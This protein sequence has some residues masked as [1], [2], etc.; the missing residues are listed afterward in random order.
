MLDHDGLPPSAVMRV[1]DWFGHPSYREDPE[2]LTQSRVLSVGSF[3][4]AVM[5]MVFIFLVEREVMPPRWMVYSAVAAALLVATNPLISRVTGK[6]RI[7]SWLAMLEL[8]VLFTLGS[9]APRNGA[10]FIVPGF[11]LV[12]TFSAFL[13]GRN[14]GIV[15]T[16]I[17]VI[18]IAWI[19]TAANESVPRAIATIVVCIAINLMAIWVID[20]FSRQRAYRRNAEAALAHALEDAERAD[21]ARRLFLANMTHDLKTPMNSILGFA[22]LIENNPKEPASPKQKEFARHIIKSGEQLLGLINQVLDLSEL[23]R[24]DAH[25]ALDDVDAATVI[26]ESIGLVGGQAAAA[27]VTVENLF[28][29]GDAVM[30]RTDAARLG[31]V[32]FN[33]LSNAIQFNRPGGTVTVARGPIEGGRLRIDVIDTGMGIAEEM[34]DHLFEP[35]AHH[36]CERHGTGV[37]IGLAVCKRIID[38]A[39]GRIGFQTAGGRGSTFWIEIPVSDGQP[40]AALRRPVAVDS[41]MSSAS[42]GA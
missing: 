39:G 20:Y 8:V 27:R 28:G 7:A 17:T 14:G 22:Q 11:F 35:F 37:G 12:P 2:L 1:L 10:G 31:Q 40:E 25:L 4:V 26:A 5:G 33:L 19:A 13:L 6:L 34:R 3:F 36:H 29:D 42:T 24:Q 30:L 15:M 18:D 16:A 38:L 21:R 9:L 23:Q 41:D 32:M